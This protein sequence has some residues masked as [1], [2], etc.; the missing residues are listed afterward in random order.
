MIPRD[1]NK[2]TESTI[3]MNSILV[4]GVQATFVNDVTS[5]SAVLEE[6][7]SPSL[8]ENEDLLV[9][10]TGDNMNEC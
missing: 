6:M 4:P 9:L 1:H 2:K 10:N 7:G 8:E 3:T 5:L